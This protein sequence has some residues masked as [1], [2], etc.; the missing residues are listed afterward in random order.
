MTQPHTTR[1]TWDIFCNVIDNWGDIGV[2]WRL[3]QNLS[4]RN[5]HVRLWIDNITALT[6]MRSPTD[7][8]IEI[9][10]WTK[11]TPKIEP[12]DVF[13]EAFG[14][15]APESYLNA[16]A[17]KA[18]HH[19]APIWINLEYLSAQSY[20]RNSHKLPSLQQFGAT[21][22][23]IRWFF[24][25]GFYRETGGLLRELDLQAQQASFNTQRWL[26]T[27]SIPVIDHALRI[28]L[29]HYHN[30][31][32]QD[33]LQQ[34]MA[35]PTPIHLLATA[36]HT[37]TQIAALNLP[38]STPSMLPSTTHHKNLTIT[39]LPYLTQKDF[40][41]LLWSCDFNMVRGEDSWIRAIWAKK[42]FIWQP[43]I[44]DDQEHL[45]K[46]EAFT[47]LIPDAPPTWK[48]FQLNWTKQ[49][50]TEWPSIANQL[51]LITYTLNEWEKHLITQPDLSSSLIEFVQQK[52]NE[53]LHSAQ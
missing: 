33:L 45:R 19:Q 48:Q 49:E 14:C 9:I 28:C 3:A 24:Y 36:G 11:N 6:W 18:Q 44:Q 1:Q 41:H 51:P 8:A 22:G 26:H 46:L 15:H 31:A 40:D 10:H 32:L 47:D 27:H 2:C 43:Y 20:T 38:P 34:W 16:V 29:F 42:P 30:Q 4:Q 50:L 13:I 23:L 21:K 5:I 35:S 53:N 7:L 17:L 12:E 52:H 39:Y 37:S 25:P